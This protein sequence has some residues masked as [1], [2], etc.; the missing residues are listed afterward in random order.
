MTNKNISL[1]AQGFLKRCQADPLFF[2]EH[3]LGGEQPWDKQQQIMLSVRDNERTA[4]PS[5]FCV[6]KT[7]VAARIAL[8]F[9]CS[10]PHSLVITTAPT[11]RQVEHVLWAEKRDCPEL[12]S[13]R[14]TR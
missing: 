10:F 7:W 2:S 5:G 9:L 1:N 11:W 14:S 12:S 3:V 4:V 8:W 13:T 6:G